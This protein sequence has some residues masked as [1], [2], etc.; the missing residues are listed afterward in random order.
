ML[1]PCGAHE[2]RLRSRAWDV[3]HPA[4]AYLRLPYSQPSFAPR[5]RGPGA[6]NLACKL[7]IDQKPCNFKADICAAARVDVLTHHVVHDARA[8]TELHCW[9]SKWSLWTAK[10][11]PPPPLLLAPY[12]SA[13][14]DLYCR[15]WRKQ[16][17]AIMLL[18]PATTP[19]NAQ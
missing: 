7:A 9:T 3:K 8:A 19:V 17:P 12:I 11:P 14:L 18:E 5:L 13:N 15:C 1:Q 6:R 4:V 16:A 2:V 10:Q